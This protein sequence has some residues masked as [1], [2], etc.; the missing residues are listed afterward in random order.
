MGI[1]SITKKIISVEDL[2]E[3]RKKNLDKKIVFCTGCFDI[4]HSGHAVFFSECKKL[5]DILVVGV[6]TDKIISELKGKNRPINPER[7]RLFLIAS[8]G[9]VDYTLLNQNTLEKN[10]IDYRETITKLKPNF[11]A[12][13]ND[14]KHLDINKAICDELGIKFTVLKRTVPDFLKQ[15]STSDIIK[16]SSS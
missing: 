8:I 3:I 15:I 12:I 10:E 9:D 13:N 7:N 2:V 16:K 5:G 14:N 11:F 1:E 6:G 4:L